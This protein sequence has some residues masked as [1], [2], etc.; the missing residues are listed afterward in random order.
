M[1]D[2]AMI[3]SFRAYLYPNNSFTESIIMNVNGKI[4]IPAGCTVL[5]IVTGAGDIGIAR[6]KKVINS[7]KSTD[8]N[9]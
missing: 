7:V 9:V 3:H 5:K 6:S 1:I 2:D 8:K 4:K